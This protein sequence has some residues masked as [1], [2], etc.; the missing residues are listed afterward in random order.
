MIQELTRLNDGFALKKIDSLGISADWVEACTFAWLAKKTVHGQVVNAG[1]VTGAKG[2]K[3][4]GCV[5]QA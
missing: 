1:P 5:Y 2:P 4:L 3:I